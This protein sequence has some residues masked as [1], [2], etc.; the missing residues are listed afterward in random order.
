[1]QQPDQP[2]FLLDNSLN[3]AI[4]EAL[5]LVGYNIRSVKEVFGEPPGGVKD[6]TIIEWLATSQAVWLTTDVAAKKRYAQTTMLNRVSVVWY[7]QP[8]QRGL[9]AKDQHW[10]VTKFLKRIESALSSGDIIHFRVGAG[11]K[12]ILLEDWRRRPDRLV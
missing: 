3:P 10:I 11:E 8:P 7:R 5:R 1:M 4:A 2:L 9:S 6:P 12:A